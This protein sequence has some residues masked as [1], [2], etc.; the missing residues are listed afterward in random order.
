MIA[1]AGSSPPVSTKSPI[2]T[3]SSARQR[4]RSSKPS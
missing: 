1:A 3:S 2:D 4:I